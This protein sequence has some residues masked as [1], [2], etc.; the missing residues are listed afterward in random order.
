MSADDILFSPISPVG[1]GHSV[2]L[3]GEV[4][5][6]HFLKFEDQRVRIHFGVDTEAVDQNGVMWLYPIKPLAVH[7]CVIE[8]VYP[9]ARTF[10]NKNRVIIA[11]NPRNG[12][13]SDSA[14]EPIQETW[15]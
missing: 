13:P 4:V 12:P 9:E 10:R 3:K 14:A 2:Y 7:E 15:P 5:P 6:D 8:I 1:A 11:T